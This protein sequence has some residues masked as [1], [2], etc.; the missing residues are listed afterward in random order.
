MN[1]VGVNRVARP[2][3]H[4]TG[5]TERQSASFFKC[6]RLSAPVALCENYNFC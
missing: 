3:Q 1:N 6:M 4:A 5:A 2:I